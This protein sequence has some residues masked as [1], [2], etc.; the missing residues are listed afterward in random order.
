M[1]FNERG[2]CIRASRAAPQPVSSAGVRPPIRRQTLIRVAQVLGWLLLVGGVIWFL[3]TFRVWIVI[4]LF[5]L[6]SAQGG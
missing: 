6:G 4:G 3:A 1:P 2:E 5:L